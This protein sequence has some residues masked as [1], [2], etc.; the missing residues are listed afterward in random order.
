MTFFVQKQPIAK[1]NTPT[2]GPLSKSFKVQA[3]SKSWS[4]NTGRETNIYRAGWEAP[5]RKQMQQQHLAHPFIWNVG[6]WL[7]DQQSVFKPVLRQRPSSIVIKPQFLFSTNNIY[8]I[9][10]RQ[11][12]AA[13]AFITK[14]YMWHYKIRHYRQ[15]NTPMYKQ[16]ESC[17]K[18]TVLGYI[19]KLWSN[20]K[21]KF[22][23]NVKSQP[24][25]YSGRY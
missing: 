21:S 5:G 2:A 6:C 12:L 20:T 8:T 14:A 25:S 17:V 15:T 1:H 3:R 22:K 7:V 24:T 4:D 19:L 23:Y 18:F 10:M 13:E 9:Q 11:T 16:H